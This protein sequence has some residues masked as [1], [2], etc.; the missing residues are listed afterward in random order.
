MA[1]QKNGL[2]FAF[3]KVQWG[4]ESNVKGE[5]GY[6]RKLAWHTGADRASKGVSARGNTLNYSN[7]DHIALDEVCA[8]I[9]SERS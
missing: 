5:M 2:I 1:K 3:A 7:L 8:E 4:N 9:T 6:T